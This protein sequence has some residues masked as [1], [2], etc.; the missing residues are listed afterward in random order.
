MEKG[1]LAEEVKKQTIVA[2]SSAETA[3]VV[4]AQACQE[5]I[6]IHQLILDS[7]LDRPELNSL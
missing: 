4:T 6:L 3:Y 1:Q 5:V 7:G 2:F